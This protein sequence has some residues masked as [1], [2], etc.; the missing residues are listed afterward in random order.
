[1]Q[2][3]ISCD[4]MPVSAM[5]S[6]ALNKYGN[7]RRLTTKPGMSGTSIGVFPS[8]LQSSRARWRVLRLASGGKASSTSFIFGTG[9]NR[10]KPT[11]FSECPLALASSAIE[12]DEVVVASTV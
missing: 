7:R 1:M 8:A 6:T 2:P 5:S 10:W 9:L 12:R 11:K 4:V 3:S